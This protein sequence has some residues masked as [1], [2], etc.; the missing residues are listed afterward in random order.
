MN[1]YVPDARITLFIRRLEAL[2]AGEKA[3]LRRSAGK[4]LSEAGDVTGLF[5]RLLPPGTQVY[6]EETYFLLAT[7]Y[8]LADA[9]K[10]ENLGASLQRARKMGV[11]SK[12]LDRRVEILLDT[13]ITQLPFRL[14][15]TVRFLKSNRVSINWVNLLD[16][17]LHWTHPDRLV[18][19]RWARSYFSLYTNKEI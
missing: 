13:E 5:Y 11:N 4:D 9:G 17:L 10:I 7:L 12:G 6:Q 19:R 15:Q 2:D 18:Q 14:R 16:D 3:K 8:P 1:E